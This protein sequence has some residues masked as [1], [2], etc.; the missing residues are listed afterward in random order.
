MNLFFKMRG[1][2]H[3]SDKV[4]GRRIFGHKLLIDLYLSYGAG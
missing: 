4:E 3:T 2:C 1:V